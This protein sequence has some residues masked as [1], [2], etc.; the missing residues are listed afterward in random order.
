MSKYEWEHGT[1]TLPS[2]DWAKFRT[3]LLKAWNDKQESS[4]KLAQRAHKA[5]VA[6]GK[7]KRGKGRQEAIKSAIARECGGKIDE[8]GRFDASRRAHSWSA[9]TT[10]PEAYEKHEAVCRLILKR[11]GYG[12]DAKVTLQSPKRKDLELHPTSKSCTIHLGDASVTFSNENRSVEW[13]VGENNRACEHARE[14]WFAGE[15]FS[16]LN[17][18]T[19][20]SRTGGKIIGNDEYNRDCDYEGGGGNYVTAEYSKAAQERERKQREQARRSSFSYTPY[21]RW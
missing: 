17:K 18:I 1:I 15:L 4:L 19:W 13:Y 21:R 3:G 11:D 7:G 5:A 16:A 2:K 9:L 12:R 14:H 20:T 8:F 6:A 10:D